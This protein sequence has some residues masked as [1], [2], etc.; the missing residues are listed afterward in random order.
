MCIFRIEQRNDKSLKY[1]NHGIVS[2]TSN[3]VNVNKCDITE[4]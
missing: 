3:N 1:E 4:E 2:L